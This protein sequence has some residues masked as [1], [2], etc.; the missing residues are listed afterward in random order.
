[1]KIRT[2][3]HVILFTIS[4]FALSAQCPSGGGGNSS[5]SGGGGIGN[6]GAIVGGGNGLNVLNQSFAGSQYQNIKSTYASIDGSPFLNN[7]PIESTLVMANGMELNNVPIQIDLYSHLVIATNDKGVQIILDG[8]YYDEIIMPFEG[9]DIVFKKADPKNPEQYYEVLYDDGDMTFFKEGNVRLNKSSTAQNSLAN[10]N[11]NFHKGKTEYFI[12]MGQQ[13][14]VK[15]KL[16]KKD[17]FSIFPDAELMA[18]KDYAKRK[19]IKFKGEADYVAVFDGI[20]SS[21]KE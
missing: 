13:E 9:Q 7:E 8:R 10:T 4:C 2:T 16:K 18:M 21:N 15:V 19:G 17:I 14:V 6:S 1:M 11:P 20:N 5:V 12:K 3:F